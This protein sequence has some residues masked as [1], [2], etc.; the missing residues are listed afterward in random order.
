MNKEKISSQEIIDLIASK[1]LISKRA[2]EEFIKMMIATIEEALLAGDI[3]KI[4]NFG[5]FKLQWNEPRKSV[6]VRTGEE[7]ILDGYH[8]VTFI[9][10]ASLKDLVN[11]PFAH[12]EPVQLD[13]ENNFVISE[14]HENEVLDPLRTFTEQASEIKDILSEIQALSVSSK[15]VASEEQVKDQEQTGIEFEVR[16][17]NEPIILDEEKVIEHAIEPTKIISEEPVLI[18]QEESQIISES[19]DDKIET[20][21]FLEIA[22]SKNRKIWFLVL[23]ILLLLAGTGSG[24]YFLYPP[25]K[26][27][28]DSTYLK[29]KKSILKMS[30]G[31][32]ITD[33]L[34]TISSWFT[35]ETK[36]TPIPETIFIPKDTSAMNSVTEKPQ[37][38]SLQYLFDNPRIYRKYLG[39]E[40]IKPGSRLTIISKRYYGNKIFWV[41]IYEANKDHIPNPDNIPVGTL[42]RIPKVDSK[43]IDST[44]PRCIQKAK[45]LHDIYVE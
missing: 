41:Y 35:P 31:V 34:N 38:D 22:K 40:R 9:P 42:I 8:K 36:Q 29:S 16:K 12:L 33:M 45:E 3:V 13:D 20:S 1:A 18:E 25:A 28:T 39:S 14:K 2:A 24:L 27:F 23:I 32:S 44:N 26:D 6:N 21:S 11:E 5:T 4:K 10:E 7:I 19:T 43:L 17:K 15:P 37:I 30:E